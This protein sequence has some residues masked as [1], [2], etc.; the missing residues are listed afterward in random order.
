[1]HMPGHPLILL[2]GPT[3]F[4]NQLLSYFQN[5]FTL[6]AAIIALLLALVLA[7]LALF[8]SYVFLRPK[9]VCSMV[10]SVHFLTVIGALLAGLLG[11]FG[12]ADVTIKG[13]GSLIIGA[14]IA[15]V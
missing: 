4:G 2:D 12:L 6:Q 8:I 1:M 10:C 5:L 13:S 15:L 9:D 14:G 3:S 7:L 11:G